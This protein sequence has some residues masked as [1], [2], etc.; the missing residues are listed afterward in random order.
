MK[1]ALGIK[2]CSRWFTLAGPYFFA[3]DESPCSFAEACQRMSHGD[4]A[5]IL[6]AVSDPKYL[7]EVNLMIRARK[8]L[9]EAIISTTLPSD[10]R[11]LR[12][13]RDTDKL[14]QF[15][16]RR[17]MFCGSSARIGELLDTFCGAQE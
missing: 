3:D 15:E 8:R 13:R 1:K 2:M 12:K 9:C 6:G 11:R 4:L 14:E 5:R 17:T 16:I 7:G 10:V